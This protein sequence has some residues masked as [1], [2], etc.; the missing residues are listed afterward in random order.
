[1]TDSQR[2]AR[3][4]AKLAAEGKT[5]LPP[6]VVSTKVAEALARFVQFKDMTMGEAVDKILDHRLVRNRSGR[7]KPRA[8]AVSTQ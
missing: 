3:R 8:Q 2:Q 1:M 7:R 5:V 6:L 4:R